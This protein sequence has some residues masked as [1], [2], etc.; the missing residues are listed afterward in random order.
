MRETRRGVAVD[1]CVFVCR[2]VSNCGIVYC[3]LTLQKERESEGGY[4]E[5]AN[6]INCEGG[7][8][9][10]ALLPRVN[11][12]IV[13]ATKIFY[14]EYTRCGFSVY[15]VVVLEN[16]IYSGWVFSEY[17]QDTTVVVPSTSLLLSL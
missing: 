9:R 10:F 16:E 5:C 15:L 6:S 8:F 7:V 13:V 12:V 1:G 4:S 14:V 2:L 3:L 11:I 17:S